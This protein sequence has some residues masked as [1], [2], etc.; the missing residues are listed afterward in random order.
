MESNKDEALRSFAIAEKYFNAENMTAARKFC[1]KSISL[2]ST[3]QAEKLLAKINS[4]AD[5]EPSPASSSTS[6]SS[7][8]STTS[9][10]SGPSSSTGTEEHPSATGMKHRHNPPK[11]TLASSSSTGPANGTSKK[12]DYTPEQLA[13]VKRVRACK[14]TEFYE[15]LA[16]KKDCEESEIKKAYRKVRCY[17]LARVSLLSSF[18]ALVT[19]FW[20]V[21]Y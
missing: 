1:T 10:T 3:P 5:K 15:I 11:E 6:S 17:H 18:Y 19:R 16:V 2:F 20:A 14:V 13:V 9:N 12:R 8:S 21:W 7:T 4:A